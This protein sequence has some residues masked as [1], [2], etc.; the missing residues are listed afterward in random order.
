MKT[1]VTIG[2]LRHSVE[3]ERPQQTSD[4]AGGATVSWVLVARVWAAIW[5]RSAGEAFRLDR[6]AGTASHDVWIRY[7]TDITPEMRVRFGTRLYNILG[8][9]DVEDR[10]KFL[11]CP[12]EERD[13]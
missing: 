4:G 11:R 9:I 8:V 5:A 7:R 6:E 2:D 12:A 10:N 13:L 3:I 1:P